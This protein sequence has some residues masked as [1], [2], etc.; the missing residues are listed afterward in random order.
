[1][2][3]RLVLC[4]HCNGWGDWGQDQVAN[5]A[6]S[7][8]WGTCGV[9]C[10]NC[11]RGGHERLGAQWQVGEEQ[12]HSM[13]DGSSPE[14]DAALGA[15]DLYAARPRVEAARE[16][17]E[18]AEVAEREAEDDA[19]V[20]AAVIGLIAPTGDPAAWLAVH[21]GAPHELFDRAPWGNGSAR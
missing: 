2:S 4:D 10:G 11:K 18:R 19:A 17:L 5:G 3:L 1:M 21:F 13:C 16:A 15:I 14:Q 8:R 7:L 12:P 6:P 20:A 9:E